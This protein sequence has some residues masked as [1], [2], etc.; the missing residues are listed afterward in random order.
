MSYN[1]LTYHVVFPTHGR[2][3][4]IAEEHEK[5]LYS[6]LTGIVKNQ[7][8]YVHAISGMPEHVH[9]VLDIPP[10]VTIADFVKAMKQHSSK[11]LRANKD[12]PLWGGWG[13]SY[14][15]FSCS[16]HD[17]GPVLRYVNNQKEHHSK[18]SFDGEL[19]YLLDL[20]HI[21]YDERRL[22]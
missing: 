9:V 5:D 8:G 19:M 21:P 1:K 22:M 12:F 14:A 4:T 3:R 15:V 18:N 11:W 7:G 20:A 17:A 16:A 13:K 6:Y 10:T 2:E